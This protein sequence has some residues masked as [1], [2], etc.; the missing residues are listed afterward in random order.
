MICFCDTL[1][2]KGIVMNIGDKIKKE[3]LKKNITQSQLANYVNTSQ[4]ALA[5]YENGSKI[6]RLD[7]I[8]RIAAALDVP[9]LSLLPSE[10]TAG[11]VKLSP[12]D[13]E[14]LSLIEEL[15]PE[16]K[17]KAR[18]YMEDLA[19]IPEYCSSK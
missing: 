3:R 15:S 4:S 14:L 1:R 7:T 2:V 10:I 16:G 13:S 19:K 12:E 8:Q 11:S 9:A 5:A 6:P 17:K 18:D